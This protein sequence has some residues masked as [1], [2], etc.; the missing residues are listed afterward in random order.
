MDRWKTAAKYTHI[1]MYRERKKAAIKKA[2]NDENVK[3]TWSKIT[4]ISSHD[5]LEIESSNLQYK[6]VL[7]E[8]WEIEREIRIQ[9][10]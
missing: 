2:Y 8:T 3:K 5:R 7:S 9:V 6:F 10:K 4:D 1:N